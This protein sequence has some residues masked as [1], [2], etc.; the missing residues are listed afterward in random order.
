MSTADDE[1][2]KEDMAEVCE[3]CGKVHDLTGVEKELNLIIN[4]VQALDE[5]RKALLVAGLL[6]QI[7]RLLE[8]AADA[9]AA[10]KSVLPYVSS[11]QT[12]VQLAGA[13]HAESMFAHEDWTRTGDSEV[14]GV[15]QSWTKLMGSMTMSA[16]DLP[17]D[18]AARLAEGKATP[19]D[20]AMIKTFVAEQTGRDPGDLNVLAIK[21]EDK[22]IDAD[23]HTGNYL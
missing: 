19:E 2:I 21:D 15:W 23:L 11:I 7:E 10:G 22:P 9:N 8:K 4:R 20:Y 16:L 6:S 1:R 18:V 17:A 3:G 12:C 14:D 13:A 5:E